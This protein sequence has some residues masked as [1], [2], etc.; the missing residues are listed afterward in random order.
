MTKAMK[1]TQILILMTF[2]AL[3]APCAQAQPQGGA[4]KV[5]KVEG[6]SAGA[7]S[8]DGILAGNT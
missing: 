7:A 8:S 1:A 2:T 3:G 5:I 6:R 4:Y